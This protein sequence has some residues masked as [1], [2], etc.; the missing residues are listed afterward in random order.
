M[1]NTYMQPQIIRNILTHSNQNIGNKQLVRSADIEQSKDLL[2]EHGVW[3]LIDLKTDSVYNKKRENSLSN[4][5][6]N[7]QFE[8]FCEL[9][10][11]NDFKSVVP[12]KGMSLLNR[13]YSEWDQRKM[14]DIDVYM[15]T[16]RKGDLHKLLIN[17][18]YI[19]FDDQKWKA[20]EHKATYVKKHSF[21]DITIEIHFKLYYH[22]NYQ[23]ILETQLKKT[24]LSKEDEL[25]YLCYHLAEQHNFIKLFWLKDIALYVDKFHT[26]I[27]WDKFHDLAKKI[28]ISRSSETC[29]FLCHKYLKS[30][31][32]F[33][34]K[35]IFIN[36]LIDWEYLCYPRKSEF[37]Y[38]LLKNY[39][40]GRRSLP[41][42]IN[43]LKAY[44]C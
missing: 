14:S 31:A 10:T 13:I 20:N 33:K 39:L 37:K 40:K 41:Y 16:T 23:P 35:N 2:S 7:S 5:F 11:S 44:K 42:L 19:A 29:L 1:Q 15:P 32:S 43:W 4:I 34:R 8:L 3:G 28:N 24:Y 26:Q 36:Q 17:N 30:K 25:L 27:N 38:F 22:T 6:F 21:V 12:I 9:L 18:G